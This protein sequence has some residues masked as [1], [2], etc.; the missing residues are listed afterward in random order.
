MEAS[1]IVAVISG[2][3]TLTGS[4]CGVVASSRL[5]AYRLE[6]LEKRVDKHNHLVERMYRAEERL[7]VQEERIGAANQRIDDLGH[8]SGLS[9]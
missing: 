8:L 7:D 4:F 1:I 9:S 3:C 5:T 6:Q 2:A